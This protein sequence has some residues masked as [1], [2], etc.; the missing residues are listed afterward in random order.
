MD[1]ALAVSKARGDGELVSLG[2]TERGLHQCPAGIAG[3]VDAPCILK[4]IARM[5]PRT[6][7]MNHTQAT[8]A[9]GVVGE[10]FYI[11]SD[12]ENVECEVMVDSG[13]QVSL[14]QEKIWRDATGGRMDL[15]R[16]YCKPVT[17][18]N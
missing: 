12:I 5:I 10:G 9:S 17:A 2:V 3:T 11:Q 13:A 6:A 4:E 15:L 8:V 1:V 16:P 14:G 7:Q 18:A